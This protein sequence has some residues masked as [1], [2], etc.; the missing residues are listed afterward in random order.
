MDF[1]KLL[2]QWQRFSWYPSKDEKTI[3]KSLTA[4]KWHQKHPDFNPTDGFHYLDRADQV[5]PISLRTGHNRVNAHVYSKL[6]IGQTDCCPCDIAPV[7]NQHLLA[8]RLPTPWCCKRRNLA[9]V[10]LS[11]GQALS[12]PAG[13]AEDIN[14]CS[15]DWC[16]HLAFE[17]EEEE[18]IHLW[19]MCTTSLDG[20]GSRTVGN[21]VFSLLLH[22]G[23]ELSLCQSFSDGCPIYSDLFWG[24][25]WWSVGIMLADEGCPVLG[26][27]DGTWHLANHHPRVEGG[28]VIGRWP[29][30]ALYIP[31][32]VRVSWRRL[33]S[34]NS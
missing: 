25:R 29:K 34:F 24:E 21:V 1:C 18:G 32:C 16:I 13:S 4:R 31:D 5:I 14:F 27:I 28:M 22:R 7:T 9:K 30:P 11:E 3:T 26:C 2:S 33:L 12:W 8:P 23:I 15:N 10:H 20:N 17:E 6:K 19:A